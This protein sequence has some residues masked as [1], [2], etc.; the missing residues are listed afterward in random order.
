MTCWMVWPS[1]SSTHFPC[2]ACGQNLMLFIAVC[3]GSV[4]AW[5]PVCLC[6][7][8][9]AH[10]TKLEPFLDLCVPPLLGGTMLIFSAS[11]QVNQMS[12]HREMFP[13]THGWVSPHRRY[14]R[15]G[16]VYSTVRYSRATP[17]PPSS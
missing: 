8:T 7:T 4:A 5:V 14:R 12:H 9:E 10:K 16:T 3:A 6:A 11:F 2:N 15:E 13:G 1:T 17:L